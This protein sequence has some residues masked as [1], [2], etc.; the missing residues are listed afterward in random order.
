MFFPVLLQGRDTAVY[1]PLLGREIHRF[2]ILSWGEIYRFFPSSPRRRKE[3]FFSVLPRGHFKLFPSSSRGRKECFSLSSSRAEIQRFTTLSWGE[4]YRFFP[5]SPTGE[6]RTVSDPSHG[7]D[8]MVS[9][10]SPVERHSVYHSLPRA[11]GETKTR[12]TGPKRVDGATL[13]LTR[14]AHNS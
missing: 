12:K 7:G 8:R 2:P 14:S 11:G 10:L 6:N 4:M 9:L 3:C 13:T 5:S 1:N